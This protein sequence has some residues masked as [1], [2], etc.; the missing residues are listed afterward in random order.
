MIA[1]ARSYVRGGTSGAR[2]LEDGLF[3]LRFH[4]FG[5]PPANL[6]LRDNEIHIW[7]SVL[8]RIILDLYKL[9]QTLSADERMRAG[10]F[11]CYEDK[12]WFILRHGILRMIL[13]GY[14]GVQPSELHFYHGKNGKPAITETSGG[15]TIQFNLSHSNGV[16]LFAFTRDHE[17][18]VDIEYIRDISDMEQL[19]GRFFS[20]QE[21]EL[22][23]S[24]PK[25]Q[26]REAFF[27][28]WTCK[29]A[30][31]KAIGDGLSR[32]LCNFDVSLTPGESSEVF[33]TEDGSKETSRWTIHNLKP[34]PHYMG[35]F[36]VKNN[37][38]QLKC[39]R[40][41]RIHK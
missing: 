32:P 22:F 4:S 35:A 23:R 13:G 14:L 37:L 40:L 41:D 3:D 36:A 19:V 29:E 10:R 31:V 15:E 7:F 28:G 12:K 20:A 39:W 38:S 5:L 27:K 16:A 34:A 2:Q 6:K 21:N 33:K 30:F 8:D 25:S 18:G 11:H 26:K 9:F 17:I 1:G 24:M